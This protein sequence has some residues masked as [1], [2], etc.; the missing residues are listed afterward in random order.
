M[1]RP[2]KYDDDGNPIVPVVE[3]SVSFKFA[4]LW[5]ADRGVFLA[6]DVAELPRGIAVS[7]ANEGIGELA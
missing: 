1:G 7:L 6:G 2:R 4:A 3:E 5:S